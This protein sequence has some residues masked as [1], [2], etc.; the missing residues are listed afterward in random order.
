M[1]IKW[2]YNGKIHTDYWWLW[3][4]VGITKHFSGTNVWSWEFHWKGSKA[5]YYNF[6]RY[7]GTATIVQ[8]ECWKQTRLAF[9]LG[10]W[11]IVFG[12]HPLSR[13]YRT[14]KVLE[15]VKFWKK[16]SVTIGKDYENHPARHACTN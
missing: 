15:V 7:S 9:R 8:R 16:V 11:I 1:R 5:W 2:A 3:S 10:K 13:S 14:T 4:K 12:G 6:K